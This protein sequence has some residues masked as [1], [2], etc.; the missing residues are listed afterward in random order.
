MRR[1]VYSLLLSAILAPCLLGWST[2]V[3]AQSPTV[4]ADAASS[5]DGWLRRGAELESR[6]QWGEV[7]SHYESA[8]RAYPNEHLL[9][10]RLETARVHYGIVRRYGDASFKQSLTNFTEKDA[11][12]H[13]DELLA[14]VQSH[15]VTEPDWQALVDHGTRSVE[16]ALANEVFMNEHL[17]DVPQDW[18]DNFRR[19]LRR[20]VGLMM[21][22]NRQEAVKAVQLAGQLGRRYLGISPTCVTMEYVHQSAAFLDEYSTYLTANQLN[23]LYAQIDGNFVGLGIELHAEKGTLQIVKVIEGS[24]A[25]RGGLKSGDRIIAVDGRPTVGMNTDQA[26]NLLQGPEESTVEVTV[27]GT[28]D[29]ARRLVLRRERVDV[30]SIDTVKMLVPESGL[31]YL[32]LSSFQKTTPR[33]LD[34]A[35]WR[36]HRAGMRTLVMDLRGNPGGLLTTSVEVADRFL[37]SGRIVSTRGRSVDQNWTY[38]AHKA[39]TWRMPLLVLIDGDSASAA[40]IFAGAIRDHHRGLIVGEKS[41]GKGSVQSIFS[42]SRGSSGLRLTTAKFYS[43]DG[44]PYSKVGVTPDLVVNRV[45]RPIDGGLANPSGE[46]DPVLAEAIRAA[47]RQV[48]PPQQ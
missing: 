41:Y 46:A 16:V 17:R 13:F 44:K 15:Y 37:E 34:E 18:I 48:Q 21:I 36:L 12:D 3:F 45:A 2:S 8:L 19:E 39:G 10:Q 22:R 35:L 24:P 14:K 20:Q 27:Q 9:Q 6:R 26:A 30:P 5:L 32:R 1:R 33:E 28:D 43:P 4:V 38:S 42:L 29:V 25:M 31:A 47:E 40:E 23:D 11:V 7:L